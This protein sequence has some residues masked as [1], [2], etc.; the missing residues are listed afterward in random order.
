MTEITRKEINELTGVKP[1]D[2]V[3]ALSKLPKK[4][5]R[6][7]HYYDVAEAKD[8]LISYITRKRDMMQRRIDS[9][10][11]QLEKIETLGDG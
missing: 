5:D 4:L 7:I 6:N 1:D 8:A 11:Q 10:N 3:L 2:I 9:L